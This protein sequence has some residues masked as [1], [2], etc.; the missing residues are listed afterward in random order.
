MKEQGILFFDLGIKWVF[1]QLKPSLE[2]HAQRQGSPSS[3]AT[4]TQS[5]SSPGEQEGRRHPRRYGTAGVGDSIWR[6]GCW[7]SEATPKGT[8]GRESGSCLTRGRLGEGSVGTHCATWNMALIS[9]HNTK[10]LHATKHKGVNTSAKWMKQQL[11][12]CA[13]GNT[14]STHYEILSCQWCGWRLF[15]H[16]CQLRACPHFLQLAKTTFP[17]TELKYLHLWMVWVQVI[18]FVSV[19]HITLLLKINPS[20]S[21]RSCRAA[22]PKINCLYKVTANLR[23]VA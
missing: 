16:E 14:P 23:T 9:Q 12:R 8:P 4:H 18:W 3:W 5:M 7:P 11:Q 13:Y 17:Y 10:V 21:S 2:G 1:K 6:S 22:P 19:K 20:H 15:W